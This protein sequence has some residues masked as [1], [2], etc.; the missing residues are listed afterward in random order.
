[1]FFHE[2]LK[3]GVCGENIP[4]VPNP[5]LHQCSCQHCTFVGDTGGHYDIANHRC[6]DEAKAA[7]A[8]RMKKELGD[9]KYQALAKKV[10]GLFSKTAK[11]K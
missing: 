6:S 10:E 5:P 4:W 2:P 8:E 1:M 11:A 7:F 9:E 3:C